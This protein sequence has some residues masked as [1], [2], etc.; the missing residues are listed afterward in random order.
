MCTSSR[1]KKEKN[2]KKKNEKKT[3]HS[4]SRLFSCLFVLFVCFP[5]PSSCMISLVCLLCVC[6]WLVCGLHG[7]WG[8]QRSAARWRP[9]R[10]TFLF[11]SARVS[12]A[13][14][15]SLVF[16]GRGQSSLFPFSTTCYHLFQPLRPCMCLAPRFTKRMVACV[17]SRPMRTRWRGPVCH[18]FAPL[19]HPP[20]RTPSCPF[21][22]NH[23]ATP[24]HMTQGPR[25]GAP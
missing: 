19:P 8:I 24:R 5:P 25:R 3:F 4:S 23:T 10:R 6:V 12:R 13:H 2:K 16:V 18:L 7:P 15:P 17:A 20:P 9:M 21:A 1:A 22:C 14:S 11:L